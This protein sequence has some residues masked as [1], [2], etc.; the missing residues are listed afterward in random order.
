MIGKLLKGVLIAPAR[1]AR[2]LEETRSKHYHGGGWRGWILAWQRNGVRI[3]S[4]AG[5]PLF[6]QY[7][8]IS[9]TVSL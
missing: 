3:S 6:H 5:I 1:T 2:V 9:N 7:M 4:V 8:L